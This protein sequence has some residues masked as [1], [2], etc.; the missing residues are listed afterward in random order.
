MPDQLSVFSIPMSALMRLQVTADTPQAAVNTVNALSKNLIDVSREVEWTTSGIDSPVQVGRPG[1]ELVL[2]DSASAAH[3]VRPPLWRSLLGG[4]GMGVVLGC[5]SVLAVALAR[6]LVRSRG[7][8][9]RLV[10]Q[11]MSDDVAWSAR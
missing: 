7:E 9:D 5:V 6:G 11:T 2:V 8:V 1:A 4:A 3:S 10:G